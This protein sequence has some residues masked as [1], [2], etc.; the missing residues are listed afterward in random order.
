MKL[1]HITQKFE[2]HIPLAL[3]E[4]WDQC[5]LQLGDP[6][7]EIKSILFAYDVCKET[8]TAAKKNKCQLI[9]THH[10]FRMKGS[11]AVRLDTYDGKL[12]EACIKNNIA[13]YCSHTNHDNSHES[14]NV[15]ILKELGLKNIQPLQPASIK[16]FVLTVGTPIA[17]AEQVKEALFAAGAGALGNYSECSFSTQ[18]TGTFKGNECANPAIGKKLIRET[19]KEEKIEVLVKE[20]DLKYVLTKM[21]EAHPYEEVAYGIYQIENKMT[22]QG[23]GA[24]GIAENAIKKDALLAQ[25]KNSFK[26]SSVRFVNSPKTKYKKIAICTGSGT[27]YLDAVIAQGADLFIT[28]DVKYHQAIHAKRHDLALADVGHFHSEQVS[29][30]ILKEIFQKIFG[31]RLNY[32]VFKGLRDPFEF[33]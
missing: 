19:V 26:I 29:V 24:C 13:L 31:K 8:I 18:G 16:L 28:G 9:V 4:S 3:Q 30:E 15:R 25:L 17:H 14:A 21:K 10:P 7:A 23:A 11:V 12:I 20:S 33:I 6:N 22:S 27:Q 32:F 1:S 2:K 5:G